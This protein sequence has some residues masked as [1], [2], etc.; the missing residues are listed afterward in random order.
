MTHKKIVIFLVATIFVFVAT[1]VAQGSQ[2]PVFRQPFTLKLR[3]DDEHFYE[4]SFDRVP[5]VLDGDVY[6]FAGEGFGLNVQID[7][8]R[9]S[10]VTYQPDNAKANVTLRFTQE[11]TKNGDMMMLTVQNH[12]KRK[13][14][15][16]AMMT[17][18][19]KS[20]IYKTSVLP[21]EVGLSSYESWPHPVVQLVLNDFRFSE[22]QQPPLG[23]P[24]ADLK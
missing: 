22:A 20:G 13:L 2:A 18:P 16:N 21:V 9:I 24:S 12:L 14:F 3:V 11:K 17:I 23:K 7:G 5:Y 4:Q 15:Y 19:S 6:L 10:R 8:E 1:C